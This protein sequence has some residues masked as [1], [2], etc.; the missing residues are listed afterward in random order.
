[1]SATME[2]IIPGEFRQ[3]EKGDI[4]WIVAEGG[5]RPGDKVR[6]RLPGDGN[7]GKIVTVTGVR[8]QRTVDVQVAGRGFLYC[9]A[10]L[11]TTEK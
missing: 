9:V 7:D 4:I 10:A 5:H 6:V 2:R 11:A 8:S 3:T 1:M